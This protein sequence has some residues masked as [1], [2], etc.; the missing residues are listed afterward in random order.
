MADI[1]S[2][3]PIQRKNMADATDYRGGNGL[4]A[5]GGV[6]SKSDN[7]I[8]TDTNAQFNSNFSSTGEKMS[9]YLI[10]RDD[11]IFASDLNFNFCVIADALSKAGDSDNFVKKNPSDTTSFY[12]SFVVQQKIA[13]FPNG[14]SSYFPA[15]LDI[16]TLTIG[17]SLLKH[18][19]GLFIYGG[20]S[21]FF[22]GNAYFNHKNRSTS[23]LSGSFYAQDDDGIGIE[24][25][26]EDIGIVLYRGGTTEDNSNWT[27]F[28]TTKFTS[29]KTSEQDGFGANWNIGQNGYVDSD[30]KLLNG[31]CAA[32]G[33]GVWS[34]GESQ[35]IPG[36]VYSFF[37][38]TDR[39]QLDL[40]RGWK[41][42][43]DV[44]S[45]SI[46]FGDEV[47]VYDTSTSK[48][49]PNNMILSD[50]LI[51]NTTVEV[52]VYLRSDFATS[53]DSLTVTI[54]G[55]STTGDATISYTSSPG[56][57]NW[58]LSIPVGNNSCSQPPSPVGVTYTA[59]IN[60]GTS[61]T[62]LSRF[63]GMRCS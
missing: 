20:G 61:S 12:G 3:W 9:L 60:N 56:L 26:S 18:D 17:Q 43:A 25:S 8:G 13:N 57:E 15:L 53:S 51:A 42:I 48:W 38:P 47:A 44:D 62:T 49:T 39:V 27:A 21:V 24:T 5:D 52:P 16:G 28:N 50:Y 31:F 55:I 19:K 2:D 54:S 10:S 35:K 40:G 32:Y 36:A 63:I 14:E 4:W 6:N 37:T 29:P 59:V 23:I 58:I 46:Y 7:S 41:I 34:T 11:K 33:G 1:R 22:C 45:C 30:I